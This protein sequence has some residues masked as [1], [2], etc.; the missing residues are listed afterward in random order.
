[1]YDDDFQGA[2][3]LGNKTSKCKISAFYI[4]LGNL[5]PQHCSRL[6]DIHL[7]MLTVACNLN[8]YG[9]HKILEPFITGIQIKFDGNLH[10]FHG[11]ISMIVADNLALN[12]NLQYFFF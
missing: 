4:V 8:K 2:N 1:M 9:Y 3:P 10:N 11:T 6:K 12:A 7:V 5:K